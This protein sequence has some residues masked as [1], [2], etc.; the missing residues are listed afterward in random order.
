MPV[1]V[2][3]TVGEMVV[4]NVARVEGS[5]EERGA[6]VVRMWDFVSLKGGGDILLVLLF[7]VPCDGVV[8]VLRGYGRVCVRLDKVLWEVS[9][10]L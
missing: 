9:F 8:L 7:G 4:K 2:H 5:V 10:E 6:K 1:M 3:D